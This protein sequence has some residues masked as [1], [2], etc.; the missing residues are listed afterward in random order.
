MFRKF[1]EDWPLSML[2]S[3]ILR[4]CALLSSIGLPREGMLLM[5]K[6]EFHEFY[7][8]KFPFTFPKDLTDN[9]F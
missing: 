5:L 2:N 1:E 7:L 9:F 6:F 3:E 8:F 4:D